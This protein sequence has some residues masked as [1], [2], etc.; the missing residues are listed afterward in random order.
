MPLLPEL[1]N[2]AL[3]QKAWNRRYGHISFSDRRDYYVR[4]AARFK[5]RV[6]ASDEA[7]SQLRDEP[8]LTEAEKKETQV[9]HLGKGRGIAAASAAPTKKPDPAV[10]YSEFWNRGDAARWGYPS[11]REFLEDQAQ[12][13]LPYQRGAPGGAA[14]R[15]SDTQMPYLSPAGPG[16]PVNPYPAKMIFKCLQCNEP[17]AIVNL[18]HCDR[19]SRM[20]GEKVYFHRPS[21]YKN[22][23]DEHTHYCCSRA[24]FGWHRPE[25]KK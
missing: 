1:V 15:S 4:R 2:L 25:R 13:N 22:C 12:D 21:K 19:C 20:M 24:L 23:Y 17:S 5:R 6:G 11:M 18:W 14:G 7:H 16:G 3:D 10:K 9:Q 8:T